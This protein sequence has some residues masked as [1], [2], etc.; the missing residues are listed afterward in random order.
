[1]ETLE[2]GLAIGIDLRNGSLSNK[3]GRVRIYCP[4]FPGSHKSGFCLRSRVVWWLHTGEIITDMEANIHH[5][6]HIPSDDRFDNLEKLSHAEHSQ[7]HNAERSE[8]AICI[9][10]CAG[11]GND[12]KILQWRLNQ[13]KGKYCSLKCYNKK[14]R[15]ISHK[16]N[17]SKGL[18]RAYKEGKR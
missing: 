12:F 10:K 17:I 6:N 14:P 3:D 7:L 15:E 5:E 1:M 4:Q 11:C 13:G 8:K 9:S 16:K 2:K 18:K